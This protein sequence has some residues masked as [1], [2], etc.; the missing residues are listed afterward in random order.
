MDVTA[1]FHN[2]SLGNSQEQP[3]SNHTTC[4]V[5]LQPTTEIAYPMCV[6]L[7]WIVTDLGV[8]R[9]QGFTQ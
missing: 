2:P 9:I 6:Y 3:R 8:G 7:G 5:L 4:G 1:L